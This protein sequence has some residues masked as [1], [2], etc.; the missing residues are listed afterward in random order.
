MISVI[1][2]DDHP[3][4]RVGLRVLLDREPDIT[5]VGE[6]DDGDAALALLETL[7]P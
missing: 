3:A 5:V 4:L 2:A 1:L 6:A 7:R